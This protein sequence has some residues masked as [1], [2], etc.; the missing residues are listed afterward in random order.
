MRGPDIIVGGVGGSGTRLVS[1]ILQALGV[2]TG[3]DF[4]ES[5]DDLFFTLLFKVREID[6]RQG[7]LKEFWG[8][9]G[10]EDACFDESIKLMHASYKMQRE[11][12]VEADEDEIDVLCRILAKVNNTIDGLPTI[13]K[14]SH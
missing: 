12:I 10:D 14:C 11:S 2:R 5:L 6:R 13:S 1:L 9:N 8:K 7:V 4:N 3:P